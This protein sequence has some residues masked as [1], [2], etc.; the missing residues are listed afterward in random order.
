MILL[1]FRWKIGYISAY[2]WPIPIPRPDLERILKSLKM[3]KRSKQ[4]LRIIK[5]STEALKTTEGEKSQTWVKC[6]IRRNPNLIESIVLFVMF[7]SCSWTQTSK[8]AKIGIHMVCALDRSTIPDIPA[9]KTAYNWPIPIPR[10]DLERILKSLKMIKQVNRIWEQL[11]GL[12]RPR[13][14]QKVKNLKL[15]SNVRFVEIPISRSLC[16]Y[17][18]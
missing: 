2:N 16:P 1:V 14:R 4:D 5:W 3:I 17:K 11:S 15:G 9:K 18:V 8:P 7:T 13:S 12:R 10:P 6:S